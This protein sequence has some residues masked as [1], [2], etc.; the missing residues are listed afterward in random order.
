MTTWIDATTTVFFPVP[1]IGIPR[2]EVSLMNSLLNKNLDNYKY[3][4][5]HQ[6]TYR[7]YEIAKV[8][9]AIYVARHQSKNTSSE[10]NANLAAGIG[11]PIEHDVFKAG[12]TFISVGFNWRANL[13]N[14]T[15]IYAIRKM[16]N[17]KV[18]M[19]CHDII[20]IKYTHF[21][22]GME[23]YYAP[24]IEAMG[25]NTDHILCD[26]HHT[27]MDLVVWLA[28]K[29]V[30]APT[31]S[32][33]PLGCELQTKDDVTYNE[34]IVPLLSIPYILL[35]STIEKR[36]NHVIICQA[37]TRLIEQGVTDLPQ[38]VFVGGVG[39]GGQEL[40]TDIRSDMRIRDK[41]TILSGLNDDDLGVLYKHCLFTVYP[42]IYEGFGLP[43]AESLAYGKLCL[44]SNSSSMPEVGGIFAVYADPGDSTAWAQ[45]ILQYTHFPN[46]LAYREKSI[47]LGY[48]SPTWADAANH[49]VKVARNLM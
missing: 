37:Y 22:P 20:P 16:I 35:V 42:S 34:A 15:R 30:Q 48:S 18:V 26:S 11:A 12:D 29:G 24:Y 27:R 49:I 2:V 4:V 31:T 36:K 44:T 33:F 10:F 39:H 13:G 9:L 3:C 21:V 5:Y 43:I 19:C 40:I 32:I 1:V 38:L 23:T 28:S 46:Q 45:L 41:V 8:D 14:L 6:P 47:A 25:K 7:Y 17:L